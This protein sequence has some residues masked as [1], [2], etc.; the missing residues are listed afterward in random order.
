MV[1]WRK[2]GSDT[3]RRLGIWAGLLVLAAGLASAQITETRAPPELEELAGRY[4]VI[5]SEMTGRYRETTRLFPKQ[6]TEELAA[7]KERMQRSGELDGM[8]AVAKEQQRFT[9]AMQQE[10]DPFELT[11]EMPADALVE[12]PVELRAQQDF[13]LKRHQDAAALRQKDIEDLTAK[14]LARIEALQRELTI[15]NRIRDAV[16]VKREHARISKGVADDSLIELAETLVQENQEV[17]ALTNPTATPASVTYGYTPHWARWVFEK[18][19]NYARE[20]TLI[21]H[22][23]IP[24][25]LAADL[26]FRAGRGR[27]QGRCEVDRMVV[28]M[29]ERAWFGKAL[30]WRVPDVTNLV[31]TIELESRELSAGS[32]YGPH[33]QLVLMADRTPLKALQVP[34]MSR[35]ATLR[36]QYDAAANR[37]NLSWLQGK[38]H[39][40]VELPEKGTWRILLG[41]AVRNPGEECDTSITLK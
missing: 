35:Q 27:I 25:E 30:V 36:V 10:R 11:P 6:Y 16:A 9:Q 40:S 33:A 22:P 20:G 4:R 26:D 29:R 3:S 32:D 2:H 8:L 41:I 5:L 28:D 31:A 34:L 12:K 21:G 13:Y 15:K 24:D 37:C 14:Y 23:D 38:A 1:G 18:R 7:L 39:E 19:Y 17:R